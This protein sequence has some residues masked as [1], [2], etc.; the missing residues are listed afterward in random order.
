M[1]QYHM[2]WLDFRIAHF[3]G[4]SFV[5]EFEIINYGEKPK[6]DFTGHKPN[7]VVK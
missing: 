4:Y 1:L 7:R 3:M 6:K 2:M 5:Y